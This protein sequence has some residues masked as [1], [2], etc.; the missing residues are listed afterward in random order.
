MKRGVK[1]NLLK[2]RDQPTQ[3]HRSLETAW[4]VGKKRQAVCS[5]QNTVCVKRGHRKA[6]AETRLE[7][8]KATEAVSTHSG[9]NAGGP[10]QSERRV[11][12]SDGCM[13]KRCPAAV[14]AAASKPFPSSAVR[15]H[16]S[17]AGALQLG[18]FTYQAAQKRPACSMTH[19]ARAAAGHAHQGTVSIFVKTHKTTS[20]CTSHTMKRHR[21]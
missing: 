11:T 7:I 9:V 15:H 6:G 17:C 18:L 2:Q 16:G 19:A 3:R 14:C 4:C 20:Q 21:K 12:W 8:F 1:E 10:S 13:R 5:G